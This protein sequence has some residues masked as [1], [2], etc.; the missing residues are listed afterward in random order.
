MIVC[1]KSNCILRTGLGPAAGTCGRRHLGVEPRC[2][3]SSWWYVGTTKN[4]RIECHAAY[5]SHRDSI[6]WQRTG[7]LLIAATADRCISIATT[8]TGSSQ[9]RSCRAD[10]RRASG[11]VWDRLRIGFGRERVFRDV[12]SIGAGKWRQKIEQA[13]AT[14]K[15]CVAVIGRR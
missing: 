3:A 7:Q 1:P 11:P 13:P 4:S 14:I 8:T 10:A 15:A 2:S 6:N 5:F 9:S 12:A